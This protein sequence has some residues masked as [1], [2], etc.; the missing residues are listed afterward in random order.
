ML[1][2]EAGDDVRAESERD[3]AVVFAPAGDVLVGVGPEEI[4]EKAAIGDLVICQQV[5][6]PT[7]SSECT[8]ISR[9]HHTSDLLH[10]VEIWAQ[11]AVHR[12]DLLVDDGGNRQAVEAVGESL[13]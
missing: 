5:G 10:G 3:T 1:L 7:P 9:A 13:P 12:E 2:Q 11:T 6:T 8:Y 4:A